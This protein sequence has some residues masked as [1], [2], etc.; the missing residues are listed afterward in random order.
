MHV[1]VDADEIDQGARPHRPAGT[2]R[3]RLVHLLGLHCGLV[4]DADAV[5]QQWNQDAVDDEA[6]GVAATHRLLASAF[7]PGIRGLDGILRA[8][9]RA[10]DFHQRED[11]RGIEEVH[12]DDTL[13]MFGCFGDL[14]NGQRRGV[15]GENR[16]RAC[17]TIELG[18]DLALELELFEHRLDDEVALGEIAERGGELEAAER[19]IAICHGQSALLDGARQI[20]LDRRASALPELVAHLA[21]D[22]VESRLDAHLRDAGAHRPEADDPDLANIHYSACASTHWKLTSPWPGSCCGTTS[23][24]SGSSLASRTSGT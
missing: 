18:K 19:R 2:V 4:E 5:V 17:Q 21:T 20:T 12:A 10:N 16:V 22:R 11:G 23:S 8:L 3:D 15:R 14:G 9:A 1:H 13:R 6:G 24:R 7:G